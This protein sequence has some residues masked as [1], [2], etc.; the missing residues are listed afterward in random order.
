MLPAI[1][2]TCNKVFDVSVV[3]DPA[4]GRRDELLSVSSLIS[5]NTGGQSTITWLVFVV[6]L[7]VCGMTGVD[8]V[9]F[10]VTSGA[11]ACEI[12]DNNNCFQSV[13]YPG[14]YGDGLAC[15][16]TVNDVGILN[17]SGFDVEPDGTCRYDYMTVKGT[18]YC[19]T[20]SPNLEIINSG[21][22]ITWFSDIYVADGYPGFKICYAPPL[23][24]CV[25]ATGGT[26]NNNACLCGTTNCLAPTSTGMFCLASHNKCSQ[27]AACTNTDG[28]QNSN[29][30]TCGAQDCTA[31]TGLFCLA[32]HN[33]AVSPG[34]CLPVMPGSDPLPN[35]DK[36]VNGD[37]YDGSNCNIEGVHGV[38]CGGLTKVVLDWRKGS[39]SLYNAV[40]A[41]YGIISNWDVS[42][43][44]NLDHV[45]YNMGNFNADLSKWVVSNVSFFAS[46]PK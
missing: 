16:I 44:T 40:V 27:V 14:N 30:C 45:F 23:D 19:G 31:S 26:V 15:T 46:S 7:S 21:T 29:A 28:S 42:S 39:G 38:S 37:P 18:K 34:Y 17:V 5:S 6:L 11:D 35:G 10:T 4:V 25:E 3:A 24:D 33:K 43:V 32:N 22:Q 12:V 8:A 41:K 13:N 9:P 1:K 20:T 2:H 36:S